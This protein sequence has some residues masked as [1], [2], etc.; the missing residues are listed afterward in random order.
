MESHLLQMVKLNFEPVQVFRLKSLFV[1]PISLFIASIGEAV[2]LDIFKHL[3]VN[4]LSCLVVAPP[5]YTNRS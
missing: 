5:S 2:Y 4:F 3:H 1:Q